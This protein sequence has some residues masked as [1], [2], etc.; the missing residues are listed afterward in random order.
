MIELWLKHVRQEG[1]VVAQTALNDTPI[2][3]TADDTE[4]FKSS[5]SDFWSIARNVLEWP[6]SRTAR[7]ADSLSVS[8]SVF[9]LATWCT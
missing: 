1:L 7:G 4:A 5:T 8:V 2:E 6:D 9:P 3:Q